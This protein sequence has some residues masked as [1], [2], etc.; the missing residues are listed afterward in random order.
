MRVT[1]FVAAGVADP[2]QGRE[3]PAR[4]GRL[5]RPLDL[6]AIDR[7]ALRHL[8]NPFIPFAAGTP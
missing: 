7:E 3:R 5:A 4:F 8:G 1:G 6:I 2:L